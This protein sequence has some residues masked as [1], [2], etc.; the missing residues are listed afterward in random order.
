MPDKPLN[1]RDIKNATPEQMRE[2]LDKHYAHIQQQDT[3]SLK[4]ALMITGHSEANGGT[5][6]HSVISG[7]AEI[8]AR[9]ILILMDELVRHDPALAVYFLV[10]F[11]QRMCGP[12]GT[13]TDMPDFNTG[14]ADV[15]A[16]F[17]NLMDRLQN[18]TPPNERNH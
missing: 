14:N 16:Q 2:E 8:L 13:D 10:N 3:K 12:Q 7:P 6:V 5:K 11:M 9:A 15:E 17:K 1:W 18:G 4:F